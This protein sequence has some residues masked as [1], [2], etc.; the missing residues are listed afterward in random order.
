MI[1]IFFIILLIILIYYFISLNIS[2]NRSKNKIFLKFS[3][4]LP[5]NT[6]NIIK[7]FIF[8]HKFFQYKYGQKMELEINKLELKYGFELNEF[9]KTNK[10]PLKN[11]NFLI[12][13]TAQNCFEIKKNDKIFI[14]KNKF[15]INNII[16]NAFL[17]NTK[18]QCINLKLN[19]LNKNEY[20]IYNNNNIIIH[21]DL[22]F[23]KFSNAIFFQ[24]I[25]DNF[26]YGYF[27]ID[28]RKQY[29]Q[30]DNLLVFPAT[31][32]FNYNSNLL[33]I[34]KYSSIQYIAHPNEIPTT[35][36]NT[37][38]GI[39]IEHDFHKSITNQLLIFKDF[40][41]LNDYSI[42]N[43]KLDKYKNIIFPMH[44][45]YISETIL[46]KLVN[47]MNSQ[48][49]DVISIG[50]ANFLN[51]IQIQHDGGKIKY[52]NYFQDENEKINFKKYNLNSYNWS[53]YKDCTYKSDENF[54]KGITFSG[55]MMDYKNNENSENYFFNIISKTNNKL[56][57]F[58]VTKY[59]KGKLIQ[60]N[61]DYVA[62][63]FLDSKKLTELFKSLVSDI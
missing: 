45:E 17:K 25:I 6:K 44:Q 24:I 50:G 3:N 5:Q 38:N 31:N 11:Q 8:P 59:T 26:F 36:D 13:T 14:H 52:I 55:E 33:K 53:D 62:V 9:D 47:I 60:F 42:E 41:I 15:N 2:N 23:E 10:N 37:W 63:R 32:F 16:I 58:T 27:A 28:N 39:D 30:N 35:T 40:D 34:N 1:T 61:S 19:D 20:I 29:E 48:N 54:L 18:N 21:A 46:K 51:K 43:I 4:Y 12:K 7:K 56:P 22:F 57:V 49:T